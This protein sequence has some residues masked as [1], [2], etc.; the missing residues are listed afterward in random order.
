MVDMKK[1]RISLGAVEG[2][3]NPQPPH[4]GAKFHLKVGF[5]G[6]LEES[7]SPRSTANLLSGLKGHSLEWNGME[8]NV[9]CDNVNSQW[10]MPPYF[11]NFTSLFYSEICYITQ[12]KLAENVVSVTLMQEGKHHKLIRLYTITV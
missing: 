6:F 5:G 12:V 1:E 10:I 11:S 4:L 3:L 9:H 7:S 2:E 8:W